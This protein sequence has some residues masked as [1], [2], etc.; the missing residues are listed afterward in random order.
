MRKI[1]AR[2]LEG[3][4]LMMALILWL[5]STLHAAG[6]DASNWPSFRGEQARGVAEGYSLPVRWDVET[7]KNVLWKT[8]VPGLG[9]SSPV[10]WGDRLFVTTAVSRDAAPTLRVGLYGDIRPVP[11][12]VVH[13]WR[14]Y[15]LD[16]TTGAVLWVRTAHEGVPKIPRHPK[17]T[18]ANPTP[19]TDGRHLVAFFGSEG[20][21]V[22][23]MD[24][25]LSWKKD[26]GVLR[27]GFFLAPDALWGFA[28]SP[29][30]HDG[31]VI[32]QSDVLGESFLAAFDVA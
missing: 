8:P 18:H 11:E 10:V 15:C 1:A 21:Y 5:A 4:W 25:N 32:V 19:A 17:S 31:K 26:L 27:S 29:V 7:S 16:K 6:K 12:K 28:S 3:P 20:L 14:V 23:D 24:G 13:S 2:W 9:H 30:I 22:Y